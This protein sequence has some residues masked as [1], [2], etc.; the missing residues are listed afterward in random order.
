MHE[1]LLRRA[2]SRH[3]EVVTKGG[4]GPFVS[5]DTKGGLQAFAAVCTEGSYAG[6]SWPAQTPNE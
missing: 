5:V 6:Q 3:L 1:R 4:K 2:A